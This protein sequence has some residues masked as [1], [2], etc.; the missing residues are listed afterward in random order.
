VK[1][2][3]ATEGDQRLTGVDHLVLTA[4]NGTMHAPPENIAVP[5]KPATIPPAVDFTIGLGGDRSGT[6]T[7]TITAVDVTNTP[8]A[9]AATASVELVAGKEVDVTVKL[10]GNAPLDMDMPIVPPGDM[11]DL[12]S[13]E[14]AACNCMHPRDCAVG[15]SCNLKMHRCEPECGDTDHTECASG[16][17]NGRI[18]VDGTAAEMCGSNGQACSVCKGGKPTCMDGVCNAK[19]G[20][21]GAGKCGAGFCCALAIPP[22]VPMCKLGDQQTACGFS[23]RNC[24]TWPNYTCKVAGIGV[25]K[26][27]KDADCM[28]S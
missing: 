18:C 15:Q 4:T 17:C 9:P 20:G 13:C 3:V 1:V 5:N 24:N 25:Y 26:C 2:R 23:C 14:S 22:A 12:I 7:V 10:R 11:P 6:L 28:P 27:C 19:C 8:L 21:P 16:C